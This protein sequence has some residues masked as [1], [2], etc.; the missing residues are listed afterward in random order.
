M[1][2]AVNDYGIVDTEGFRKFLRVCAAFTGR[3]VNYNELGDAADVSGIT[4]KEW[5][6]ILQS[7]GIIFLLEPYAANELKRLSRRLSC[8]FA[9]RASARTSLLG[10]RE[11]SL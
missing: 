2:D 9:I 4:A 1:R 8:S 3:L 5:V 7:M 11:T 10:R 6:K